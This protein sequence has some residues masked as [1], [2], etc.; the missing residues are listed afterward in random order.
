M[1]GGVI[2]TS[3][4]TCCALGW[5]D[6]PTGLRGCTVAAAAWY[7]EHGLPDDA[8]HHALAAGEMAWA[9]RLIEEH[10]DSLFYLNGEP[11]TINRW[12]QALPD[13]L[14]RSPAPAPAGTISKWQPCAVTWRRW[15]RLSPRPSKQRWAQS[16]S[17]SRRPRA[18]PVAYW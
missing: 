11:A 8:I 4:L 9:A 10:F 6:S 2:T 7:D 3:S 1:A 5:T 18:G 13:D 17:R 14:V 16:S 12:L 15:S